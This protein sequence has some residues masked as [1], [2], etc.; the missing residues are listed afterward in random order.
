MV[1][2]P[3]ALFG[4]TSSLNIAS[5]LNPTLSSDTSSSS[6][7]ST[8]FI[9]PTSYRDRSLSLTQP[10]ILGYYVSAPSLLRQLGT[11][12]GLRGQSFDP[13]E[14]ESAAESGEPNPCGIHGLAHHAWTEAGQF[15]RG[16]ASAPRNA[17]RPDNLKWE[18]P[19]GAA[20]GVLIAEG[21]QPLAD[22][23]QGKN[24]QDI[25]R[26]WSNIGLGVEIGSSGLVY[27]LGCAAHRSYLRDTGLTTLDALAA[28]GATNL[29]LKLAFNRQF[30]YTHGSKGE[31]WEG[32]RSF[33]SGHAMVSWA[34][35]A[36]VAHRYPHKRWL[37]WGA[38]GLA[39]GV[40]LSRYPA[41][42]HYA[43]DILVGSALG[44][45]TGT[46]MAEH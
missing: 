3:A 27:A 45:V 42:R 23:I 46:Y 41:K 6:I 13:T 25:S 24:I 40:A 38:Y 11:Q 12:S 36:A 1:L 16:L 29:V 34:F 43:S 33:P 30:P 44:Y 31:F 19:I 10:P 7:R 32:G 5:P 17:V 2:V 28:A 14:K 9:Q 8:S 26:L 15:S 4:Q 35:A 20:T 39:T 18:L 21:D 37:K 22:R